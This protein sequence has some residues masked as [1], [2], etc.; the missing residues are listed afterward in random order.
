MAASLLTQPSHLLPSEKISTS[1]RPG[2]PKKKRSKHGL[3]IT[4]V[5]SSA[6][7][8]GDMLVQVEHTVC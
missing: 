4:I 7:W 1:G 5:S 2:A 3:D 6:E 8:I